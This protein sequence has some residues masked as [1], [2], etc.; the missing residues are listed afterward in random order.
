MSAATK[1]AKE[2][3]EEYARGAEKL[4]LAIRGLTR[5]DLIA[6]PEPGADVG[7]WSIQEVV[8]HLQD[9]EFAFA[10]RVKRVLAEDNPAYDAWDENRYVER[11]VYDR[12][13]AADAVEIVTRL[14]SQVTE[15]LRAMPDDAFNR[16][17]THPE[18]GRQTVTDILGYAVW[19][20]DHHVKFIHRKREKMGKEMW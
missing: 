19:H 1:S 4:A 13:S 9:G 12:Q 15:I 16:T 10:H 20:I 11:L 14:R 3:V 18:R 2:L 8:I 6:K 5:E 7:L 17:G